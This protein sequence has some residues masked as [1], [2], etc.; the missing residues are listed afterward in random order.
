MGRAFDLE[1]V[2]ASGNV[3]HATAAVDCRDWTENGFR[4]TQ[5]TLEIRW[6]GGEAT[7]VD[8]HYH[9]ALCR[10]REQLAGVGLTPRCYGA[11]RNLVLSGMC[12]DMGLGAR[13]Y[14]VRLGQPARMSDLVDIFQ[15]GPEMD[16]ASVAEQATFKELWLRSLN[17]PT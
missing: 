14:L 15:S 3:V 6:P 17:S 16:L 8:W 7:G 4:K 2:D 13:G 1:L 12:V 9:A 5:V 11:C 10:V